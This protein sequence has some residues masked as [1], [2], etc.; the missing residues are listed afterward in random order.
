MIEA[1]PAEAR[2]GALSPDR[3]TRLKAEFD[4]QGFVIL[5]NAIPL[6]AL[7]ALA[8]RFCD[9]H[10]AQ[11]VAAKLAEAPDA[12]LHDQGW[13]VAG[14]FPRTAPFVHAGIV[15][16]PLVEAAVA[17][18]LGAGAFLSFCNG[19]CNATRPAR[20]AAEDSPPPPDPYSAEGFVEGGLHH[21]GPW[22][23][24][25]RAA[26]AAA[27]LAGRWPAQASSPCQGGPVPP[28]VSCH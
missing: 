15:A 23:Y 17:A 27:G 3:L 13:A 10:A 20:A 8:S 24:R 1:T 5:R 21:D 25:T 16:N 19:N 4:E 28:P 7:H 6:G 2:A 22:V 18:I 9:L 26:A 14:G 12:A 11:Q